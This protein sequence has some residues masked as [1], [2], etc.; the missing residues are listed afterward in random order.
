MLALKLQNPE[1]GT[2]ISEIGPGSAILIDGSGTVLPVW[3]GAKI[4]PMVNESEK[5]VLRAIR[6]LEN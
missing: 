5:V 6:G 4:T 3:A 1:E 2:E